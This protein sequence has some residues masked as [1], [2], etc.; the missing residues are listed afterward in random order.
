MMRYTR[1][2]IEANENPPNEERENLYRT[3]RDFKEFYGYDFKMKSNPSTMC[4]RAMANMAWFLRFEMQ[5]R[6]SEIQE[7]RESIR[8]VQ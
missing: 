7:K 1:V 5:M 3:L 4:S 6:R 2:H 8:M